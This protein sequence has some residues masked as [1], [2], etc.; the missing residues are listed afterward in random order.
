MKILYSC[1]KANDIWCAK[2]AQ[3]SEAF[4][5]RTR[6]FCSKLQRGERGLDEWC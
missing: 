4:L 3:I 1:A 2:S 6:I 5:Q